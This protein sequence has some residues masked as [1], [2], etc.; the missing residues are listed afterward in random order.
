MKEAIK[1]ASKQYKYQVEIRYSSLRFDDVAFCNT[2]ADVHT[3]ADKHIDTVCNNLFPF[4]KEYT[5]LGEEEFAK[6]HLEA[7]RVDYYKGETPVDI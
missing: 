4:I 3:I 2:V 1:V 5:K 7:Y 6:Q